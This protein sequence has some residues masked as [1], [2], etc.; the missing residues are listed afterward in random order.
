MVD[1]DLY[2]AHILISINQDLE[3]LGAALIEHNVMLSPNSPEFKMYMEAYL[4]MSPTTL[5]RTVLY[6]NG[7]ICIKINEF[8][9]N[10]NDHLG[11]LVHELSHVCMYTFDRIGMPHNMDTDEAYSYLIAFLMRKFFDNVR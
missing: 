1:L 9:I 8:N 2:N 10:D 11:T 6:E 5:A 7:V 3:D 4:H